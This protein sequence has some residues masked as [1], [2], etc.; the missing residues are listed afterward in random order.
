MNDMK[1]KRPGLWRRLV[2]GGMAGLTGLACAACC[3]IPVLVAAG[4]VGG[5]GWAALGEVMPGIA[6]AMAALTGLAWWLLR[7]RRQAAHGT[8]CQGGAC[9]CGTT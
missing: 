4:V 2:P 1:P 3:A 8:G 7:R 6:V 5:A 9:A